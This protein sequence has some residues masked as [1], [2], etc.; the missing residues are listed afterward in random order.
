MADRASRADKVLFTSAPSEMMDSTGFGTVP[1]RY[2]PGVQL[3]TKSPDGARPALVAV[4]LSASPYP[5]RARQG[6]FASTSTFTTESGSLS[7]ILDPHDPPHFACFSRPAV[8]P[9]R[10]LVCILENPPD[11]PVPKVGLPAPF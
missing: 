11:R 9:A 10:S 5:F 3:P 1:K 4:I 7:L 2:L 8:E 6:M